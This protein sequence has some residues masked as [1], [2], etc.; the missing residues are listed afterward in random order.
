MHTYLMVFL[1]PASIQISP[2]FRDYQTP[3]NHTAAA[4]GASGYPSIWEAYSPAEITDKHRGCSKNLSELSTRQMNNSKEE[5]L[6]NTKQ[7][8]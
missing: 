6:N 7:G 1:F 4:A 3:I 2:E 8:C 5:K